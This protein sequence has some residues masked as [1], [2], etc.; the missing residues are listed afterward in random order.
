M[1]N[2]IPLDPLYLQTHTEQQI[3]AL[4]QQMVASVG[5]R[6][7]EDGNHLLLTGQDTSYN[8]ADPWIPHV[9]PRF[10]ADLTRRNT[11]SYRS[12]EKYFDLFLRTAG[13]AIFS[14]R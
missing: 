4:I 3:H 14:L 5:W 9:V 6:L 8:K 2:P 10:R 12:S 13:A 11:L 1:T 7:T